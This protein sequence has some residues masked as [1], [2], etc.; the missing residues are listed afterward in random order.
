MLS[1]KAKR[2]YLL[3]LQV[4]RYCLL[5]LHGSMATCRVVL[6]EAVDGCICFTRKIQHGGDWQRSRPQ[7]PKNVH[8]FLMTL[9][10]QSWACGHGTDMLLILIK[11]FLTWLLPDFFRY[12]SPKKCPTILYAVNP[13]LK[14]I[15]RQ[16]NIIMVRLRGASLWPK[17]D[18]F[19]SDNTCN[20]RG[21]RGA[22][23]SFP[24]K[25][26]AFV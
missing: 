23:R 26:K 16:G 22:T 2:Q 1:C 25:H 10:P 9:R 3:T 20:W 15:W 7:G 6:S 12:D 24:V 19:P 14:A 5:A 8:S 13:W 18:L 11:T 21:L 17:R 4:S